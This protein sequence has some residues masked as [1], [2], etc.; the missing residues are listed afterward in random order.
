[1]STTATPK[2]ADPCKV[3]SPLAVASYPW[4]HEKQRQKD[5]STAK[6]KYGMTLLWTPEL[7]KLPGEMERFKAVQAALMA[8]GVKK[9][10]EER[11][12]KLLKSDTFKK[13]LRTDWEA[14]DYPEGTIFV[15]VRSD[16][17]PGIVYADLKRVAQEDIQKVIY[18]G[19][20]V[21]VSLTAYGYDRKDSKG[22]TLGLNNVQF[23]K[24]GPRLD[25]R[26]APEDEFTADL[27][28]APA[29]MSSLL[30]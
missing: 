8:A 10:G 15:N 14:K 19:A 29:D 2:A 3:I 6:P 12:A 18:P 25:S 21:R 1:M 27:S 17:Q 30:G 26:K 5:D 9:F 22:I 4:L 28:A 23:I 13:A 20:I 7:L 24:D 11:F 16:Q